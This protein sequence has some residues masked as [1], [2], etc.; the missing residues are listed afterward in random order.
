[1][2]LLIGGDIMGYQQINLQ[3]IGYFLAVARHLNFTEA[4]KSLYVSQPSLSKQIALL[5]NEIGVQ[6]FLRT[7]RSV[8]LTS[9]G[10]VLYNE[11][12]DIVETIDKAIEKSRNTNVTYE[13]TVNI[14]C[15]EAM[16]I[17]LFLFN[18]IEYFKSLYPNISFVI[19]RHTFKTLREKLVNGNLDMILTLSFEM[20]DSLELLSRTIYE[21]NSCILMPATHPKA[22]NKDLT[23]KDLKEEKFVLISREESPHGF[24]SVVALCK[25]NGFTPKIVKQVPNAESLLLCVESGLG[26][27][28]VDTNVRI[29]DQSKLKKINLENDYISVVMA[30]KKENQNPVIQ[31]FVDKML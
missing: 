13:G 22:K 2:R 16:D 26:I 1:M 20:D 17:N 4:A 15:L 30:W 11:L 25:A 3:Q 18:S 27:S 12:S 21:T 31:L 28:I 29:Y 7:K 23:L 19:E 8:R 5:E 9:A 14:G 6:L 24:D 10:V